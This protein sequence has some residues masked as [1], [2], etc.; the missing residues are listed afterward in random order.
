MVTF[1]VSCIT[2]AIKKEM[3]YRV[4]SQFMIKTVFTFLQHLEVVA[5]K[6]YILKI[7]QNAKA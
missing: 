2:K 4:L 7:W 5:N 6:Q 1:S 3:L